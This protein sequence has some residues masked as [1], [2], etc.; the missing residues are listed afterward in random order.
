M[1]EALK[2][3]SE[4]NDEASK[5]YQNYVRQLETQQE[6]L[7][8]EVCYQLLVVSIIRSCQSIIFLHFF[9]YYAIINSHIFSNNYSL[10][11]RKN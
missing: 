9:L 7:V 8:N 10:N 5:Q 1:K 6:T 4:E 2:T 11:I 3:V